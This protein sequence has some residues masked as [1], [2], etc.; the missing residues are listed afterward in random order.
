MAR[1]V[2]LTSI[3][4]SLSLVASETADEDADNQISLPYIGHLGPRNFS[5]YDLMRFNLSRPSYLPLPPLFASHTSE[6]QGLAQE[7]E[8]DTEDEGDYEYGE[9]N[10]KARRFTDELYPQDI[11]KYLDSG[12]DPFSDF[13]FDG[14]SLRKPRSLDQTSPKR[15]RRFTDKMIG[16]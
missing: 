2:L 5:I 10:S 4:I 14:P 11:V 15:Q 3:I 9:P 12:D 6:D 7:K 1:S 8:E 13:L 16:T